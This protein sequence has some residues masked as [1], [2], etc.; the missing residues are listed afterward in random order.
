M[1]A[2]KKIFIHIGQHKTGSTS[3]QQAL[4]NNSDTLKK[5]IYFIIEKNQMVKKM[6]MLVHGL[7]P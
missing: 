6:P 7:N 3:I 5:I 4:Y 2:T 1:K